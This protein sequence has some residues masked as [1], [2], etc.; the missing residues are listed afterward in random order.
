MKNTS[1]MTDVTDL[2]GSARQGSAC[3]GGYVHMLI[4]II[5]T[6]STSPSWKNKVVYKL[7]S[8][9]VKH[10]RHGKLKKTQLREAT[11]G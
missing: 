9:P 10:M 1:G 8:Q 11:N 2:K 5:K 3:I 4:V 6:I 7:L